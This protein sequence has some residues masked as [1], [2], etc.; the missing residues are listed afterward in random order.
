[1]SLCMSV[2]EGEEE[3][4]RE[5]EREGEMEGGKKRSD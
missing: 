2:R 4:G 1:M 5:E 3:G